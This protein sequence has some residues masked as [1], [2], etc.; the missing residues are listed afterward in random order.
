MTTSL[1]APEISESMPT[2]MD[3]THWLPRCSSVYSRMVA[4][5]GRADSVMGGAVVEGRSLRGSRMIGAAGARQR[6]EQ[7]ALRRVVRRRPPPAL[8]PPG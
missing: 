3:S 1:S 5:V 8:S 6:R 2:T 7:R 4:G